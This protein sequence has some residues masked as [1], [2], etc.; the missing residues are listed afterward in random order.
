LAALLTATVAGVLVNSLPDRK[1]EE[2]AERS[3][4]T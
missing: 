1:K 2:I 3:G 4:S